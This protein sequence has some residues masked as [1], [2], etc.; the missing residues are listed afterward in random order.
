MEEIIWSKLALIDLDRIH[1]FIALDSPFYARKTVEQI[2]K[3]VEILRRYP[4][5]GRTVP[6]YKRKDIRELIEGNYRLFY[7][8]R[9]QKISIV[10]IHHS[11]Q[12][13]RNKRRL[14]KKPKTH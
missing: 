9:K 14:A 3:R 10:R 5:S 6:E 7:R 12:I 11:A 2:L 1:D 8:I 4:E 13:I